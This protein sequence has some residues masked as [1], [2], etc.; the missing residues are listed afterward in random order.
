VTPLILLFHEGYLY[1]GDTAVGAI[2]RYDA[3]TGA[4]VDNFIPDNGQG[5]GT[6]FDLQHF[7]FGPDKNLYVAAEL[8][9]RILRYD[10]QTG[11]FIGDF[12]PSSEGFSP[13]GLTFGPDPA[14]TL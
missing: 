2:R 11:N 1:V 5:I 4:Y 9:K 12:V 13:S 6:P 14:R 10:G 3:K 8:S 7:A